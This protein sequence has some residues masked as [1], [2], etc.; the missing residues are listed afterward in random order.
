MGDPEKVQIG[1]ASVTFAPPVPM[2]GKSA[3]AALLRL[4]AMVG[5]FAIEG[6]RSKFS[7]D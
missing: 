4:I 2:L 7:E 6:S 1:S 3:L 5:A